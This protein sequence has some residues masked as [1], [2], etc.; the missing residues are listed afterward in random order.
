VTILY[1][2]ILVMD[3]SNSD[4]ILLMNKLEWLLLFENECT[5]THVDKKEAVAL[6]L[7]ECCG[8]LKLSSDNDTDGLKQLCHQFLDGQYADILR[9]EVAK[10]VLLLGVDVA[11]DPNHNDSLLHFLQERLLSYC[12]EGK[13]AIVTLMELEI[14]GAASLNLFLQLNYTGP[15]IELS[16]LDD[17]NPHPFMSTFIP[18]DEKNG[19][20]PTSPTPPHN[21]FHNFIL[22][23]LAV[24]GELPCQVCEGPYFLY[25]ARIILL[26]LAH[27]TL[28]ETEED[29][30]L[31]WTKPGS[32]T[33]INTKCSILQQAHIE[34]RL[35]HL[36]S[37]RAAVA[38]QRL[39]NPLDPS[40]TLWREINQM[41]QHI[42]ERTLLAKSSCEKLQD[43]G[44]FVAQIMLERGLAEHHF[45]RKGRGREYFRKAQDYSGLQV[46]LT[47]SQGKR[48]KYQQ[49]STA[50]LLV[51]THNIHNNKIYT[52]LNGHPPSNGTAVIESNAAVIPTMIPHSEEEI[53]LEKVQYENDD[54]NS[55]DKLS[56]LDQSI[57][58]SLCL[59]VKNN[60]PLDGLTA[61]EMGAYLERVLVQHDD[62]M[63][64]STALLERV[65]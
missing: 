9:G 65:S 23:K 11:E 56:P 62:W 17:I 2:Y 45:N 21:R 53:L 48:T 1:L 28:G 42:E 39:L 30:Q 33:V 26:H 50:Q 22:S 27:F 4:A 37:A 51:R 59:N 63:I 43:Q 40:E 8:T 19:G 47:G 38:H 35:V 52:T 64:F 6:L 60:N 31:F 18:S 29:S 5:V 36:W 12:G 61:E 46:D 57:L 54:D 55:P 7:E 32:S 10:T 25:L 49:K 16:N 34:L 13:A 24:D 14:I 20:D 44:K 58:L 15:S 41:F 3:C